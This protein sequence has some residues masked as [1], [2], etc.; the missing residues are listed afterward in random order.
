MIKSCASAF[1]QAAF[2]SAKVTS[3]RPYLIFSSIVVA[4]NTGSWPT[5]PTWLL[6]HFRFRSLTSTPSNS[7]WTCI[8]LKYCLL[9]TTC[10]NYCVLFVHVCSCVYEK[11]KCPFKTFHSMMKAVARIFMIINYLELLNMKIRATF[12]QTSCFFWQLNCYNQGCRNYFLHGG[13]G[14]GG[15]SKN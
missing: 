2:I 1:S 8:L 10:R 7:T 9:A 6:N 13:G 12:L 14:G 4:N 5:S 15:N 11:F 3:S